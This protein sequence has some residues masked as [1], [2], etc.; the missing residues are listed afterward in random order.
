MTTSWNIVPVPTR[1]WAEL[2]HPELDREAAYEKLWE[3]VAH[4]CRLETEIR[5]PR[6]SSARTS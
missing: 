6:G 1:S 2:V 3:D 5:P 4:I